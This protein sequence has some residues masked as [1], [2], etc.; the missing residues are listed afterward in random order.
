MW[1][2]E[3]ESLRPLGLGGL[4]FESYIF[5]EGLEHGGLEFESLGLLG[6]GGLEFESLV[7]N[8]GEV[9]PTEFLGF[10]LG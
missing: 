1:G 8:L 2:L 9:G 3:F 7:F 4:E 6:L 10:R 5:G